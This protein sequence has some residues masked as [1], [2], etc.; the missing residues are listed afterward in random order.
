MDFIITLLICLGI[1]HLISWAFRKIGLPNIL[2]HMTTGLV[3]SIPFFSNILFSELNSKTLFSSLAN[4]GLIFL[5]FFIGLKINVHKLI[6]F[7][8]KSLSIAFMSAAVPFVFG[9]VF[10]RLIGLDNASALILG[11]CLS[12]TAEAV[13]AAILQE[14]RM[15]N[16]Y[17][18]TIVLE[19]GI[20]DDVFE[21]LILAIVGSLIRK[22]TNTGS[23]IGVENIL[24]DIVLF[25]AIIYLVRFI[26][27][28]LTFKMLDKKPTHHELF[29][30]SFIVVLLM[31]AIA[32][33]LQLGVVIGALIAGIIVKQTL[34][35]EHKVEEETEVVDIIE[36]ITFGFLEPVFFIWIA[37]TA[38]LLNLMRYN[39]W[40]LMIAG[41]IIVIATAG[42]LLGAMIG[43]LFEGGTIKEGIFIGWG[44]NARGA[45]ELIAVK[46]AYD[47]NLITPLIFSSVILMTFVTTIISPI[48]FKYNAKIYYTH[49]KKQKIAAATKD[50]SKI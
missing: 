37:Y 23:F 32:N 10:G 42:K 6:E 24:I 4:L 41:S 50:I 31:A 33:F 20:I 18:G 45:V 40:F 49:H 9:M 28:P 21:I 29:T 46:L 1:T 38:D 7:S 39:R 3:I 8:R 14:L 35:K 13:S 16:T 25:I 47:N 11:A 15:L 2:G 22:T 43:N 12:V 5:L 26:F 30:A 27:I 19:A 44:I 36:T 34:L 48:I 17:I